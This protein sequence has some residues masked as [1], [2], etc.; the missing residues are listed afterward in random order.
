MKVHDRSRRSNHPTTCLLTPA[1]V[2]AC[3]PGVYMAP[4]TF[5]RRPVVWVEAISRNRGT[6]LQAPNFAYGLVARK[7]SDLARCGTIT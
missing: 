5:I 1:V 4:A 3:T 7:F 2:A 6:H